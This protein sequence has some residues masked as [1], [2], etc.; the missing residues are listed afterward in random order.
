MRKICVFTGTRADYG[1]LQPLM[2]EISRTSGLALQVIASGTHLSPEFGNTSL[3]IEK[4]GF[5]IDAEVDIE[6]N[7]DTSKGIGKSAGLGLINYSET[8][9]RLQPDLVVLL[10]DRYEAFAM[11]AAAT[12]CKIPIAHLHG[13]ELSFGA[14]DEAFRH[15]ITKMSHLHFTS[16]ETY[17]QRVIQLGEAPER[18]FNVGALGVENIRSLPLLD[19]DSLEKA[20][21]FHLGESV[22]LVTFH[23]VTLENNTAGSQFQELLLALEGFSQFTIIF[24]KANA[25]MDGR[26][27]NQMIDT[28]VAQHPDRSCSFTSMGQ[29]RYLSTMQ[30]AAAVIGNSSSGIIEAPSLNVPTINIGDRQKG[31]IKAPSVIDCQPTETAITEALKLA[32]SR[33]FQETTRKGCNPYEKKGTTAGILRTLKKY[34]L[35]NIL[36]K[37]F[38]D[39]PTGTPALPVDK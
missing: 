17:R 12:I 22:L 2:R 13:G 7:S 38:Y 10:G 30:Q 34:D 26:V 19:R 25:D 28:F 27:I 39:L 21:N 24:T 15:A 35:T 18:V 11:A 37:E 4:D 20:I 6:L 9:S 29:L 14:I 16:T 1:L 33:S 36:K 5:R 8:L 31:R 3:E 32:T 23:P